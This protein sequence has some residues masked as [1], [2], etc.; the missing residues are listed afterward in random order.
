MATIKT[1]AGRAKLAPRR[2]P[3]WEQIVVGK[4]LG[5][6]AGPGTWVAKVHQDGSRQIARLGDLVDLPDYKDALEAARGFFFHVDGGGSSNR[7]TVKQAMEKYIAGIRGG[8]AGKNK[9]ALTD[10]QREAKA[11]D[12]ERFVRHALGDLAA[13][14][15]TSLT[16]GA[17]QKWRE[18]LKE[19]KSSSSVNRMMTTL[20]AGL[21]FALEQRMVTSD[22]AWSKALKSIEN[23][24]SR[25]ERY[26][27]KDERRQLLQHMRDDFR[28]YA[29]LLC[30]LPLRPGDPEEMLVKHYDLRTHTLTIPAGKTASRRIPISVEAEEVLKAACKDKL[31]GAF[32]FTQQNGNRWLKEA[33]REA[34]QDARKS[35][36]LDDDVV[37]YAIRSSV[38]TDMIVGGADPLTVAK[39]SGT[40]MQMIQKHYG[41]LVD[42]HA[43]QALSLVSL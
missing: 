12:V 40:S 25:R 5:F 37:L 18:Q 31:P 27:T 1:A 23:A 10:E 17:V 6:R 2:E 30:L 22:V 43:R 42:A 26:V 14:Q 38:I 8:V 20:R 29:K 7:S 39:I 28:P 9:G 35:A 13:K 4:H 32:L 15:L 16:H 3:Y 33:R 21:N 41:H 19:G 11:K 24:G 36:K 34:V